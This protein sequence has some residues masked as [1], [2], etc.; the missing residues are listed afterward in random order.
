MDQP[1]SGSSTVL[2]RRRALRLL[3]GLSLTAATAAACTG[4]PDKKPA[5]RPGGGGN[6][7]P[8]TPAKPAGPYPADGT[9]GPN[10]LNRPG[11][12]RADLRTSLGS[13]KLPVPGVPLRIVLAVRDTHRNCAPRAK[14]A[15]YLWQCD[16]D[17]RYSLYSP[18][19]TSQTYLRGVQETGA[20]GRVSFLSVFPGV[21]AGRWPHL[22]VAVFASAQEAAKPGA[23]KLLTAQLAL[24][25]AICRLVYATPGYAPAAKALAKLRMGTDPVFGGRTPPPMPKTS[26]NVRTGF[27]T[28][29]TIGL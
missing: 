17:G 10:V 11:I 15:V 12:R 6:D 26:G 1:L 21:D 5:A 4:D 28:E 27:T 8:A 20:D 23:K 18:G 14:A 13:P 7:C 3:A 25:E 16:R 2:A 29:L 9:N 24:P 19:A 22:H